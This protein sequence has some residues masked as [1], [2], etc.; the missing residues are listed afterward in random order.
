MKKLL[1]YLF[2]VAAVVSFTGC[3]SS[4]VATQQN[5]D[6]AFSPEAL[7]RKIAGNKQTADYITAK[8]KFDLKTEGKDASVSGNLRMKRD[9]VIQMSVVPFGFIEAARIEFTKEGI[10]FVDRINRRFTRVAYSEID[11]FKKANLDFYVIQSLFWNELFIIG[12]KNASDNAVSKFTAVKLENGDAAIEQKASHRGLIVK[13]AASLANQLL[14]QVVINGPEAREATQFLW[15]YSNYTNFSGRKYPQMM[16]MKLDCFS[17]PVD[18]NMTLSRI[19]TDKKWETRT[20][21]KESYKEISAEQMM[22]KIMS[23]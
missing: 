12:D 16:H 21:V 3:R 20:A 2:I 15:G 17:R 19:S 9:D 18:L 23:L 1:K 4:K 5:E 11:F 22:K 14:S 10:L 8:V 6:K 13:F 7:I